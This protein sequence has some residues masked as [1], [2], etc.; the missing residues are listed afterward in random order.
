VGLAASNGG[1]VFSL[2]FDNAKWDSQAVK[3]GQQLLDH[4]HTLLARCESPVQ[5]KTAPR[6]YLTC[7]D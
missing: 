6:G 2:K 7:S 4:N 5:L 3:P 1:Q